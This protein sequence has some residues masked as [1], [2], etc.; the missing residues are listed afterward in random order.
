MT[1][2]QSAKSRE[3]EAADAYLKF[4]Q[5][6]GASSR[7]LYLRSKFLDSFMVELTAKIQTRK[8]FAAALELTLSALSDDERSNALNTARE[9]Y[10]F[11]MNDIKA[12]AM[13]EE[14][15]GFNVT[16]IQWKPKHTTLKAVT[17]ELEVT[18]LN[19][20]ESQ[21]LNRYRHLL[22]Q[23]GAN[24]SVIDIR[25]KLAKL[26]LLRLRDAPTTNHAIYRISV[27]L[28]LPLFKTKEIKQ[29]YLDVVREFYYFWLDDP[30]AEIKAF[31]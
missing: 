25:T 30:D 28:T 29:L 12:I 2:K 21:A 20:I 9:Y 23:K 31:N 5:A 1:T 13:F 3:R 19:E 7:A 11:W 14:Y 8:E 22:I 6:K 27:D 18:K 10:P 15:Y 17:D 24:K 26:I 4:L 16:D